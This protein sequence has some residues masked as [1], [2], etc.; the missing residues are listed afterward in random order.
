MHSVRD[1][2][3]FYEPGASQPRDLSQETSAKGS[4]PRDPSQGISTRG[5][6]PGD[7][8]QGI[9]A[10]RHQPRDLSQETTARGSQP[11]D[12][13]QGL[14]AER[15]QPGDLF[16]AILLP[17]GTLGPPKIHFFAVWSA[18]VRTFAHRARAGTISSEFGDPRG[19]P[20]VSRRHERRPSGVMVKL[21][22]A[23][24]GGALA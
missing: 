19:D 21:H 18:R 15:P 23:L 11:G 2:H 16:G 24:L 10:K 12:V 3:Y 14:S 17:L 4:H 20:N 8:S 5:S 6:R 9:S 13:A 7:L 1:W 22:V